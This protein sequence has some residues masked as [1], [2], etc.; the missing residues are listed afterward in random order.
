[1]SL[2]HPRLIVLTGLLASLG[3]SGARA[4]DETDEY[5]AIPWSQRGSVTQRVAYTDIRIVYSRPMA[6]GRTLFGGVVGWGGTWT[7][8][9]DSATT[10]SLSRAI[11]I[12]GHLLPAGRYSIW[13]VPRADS[14]WT[15]I[16]NARADVLH[17]P[18][19]GEQFD[20][21]RFEVEPSAGEYV[22]NLTFDMPTVARNS[23][24]LRFHWGTTVIALAIE[25][26]DEP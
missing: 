6:R 16:F 8:G 11:A 13:M 21:L 18:Y 19:P 4:Q 12:D 14:A 26:S 10:L 23:A 25:A 15:V 2:V 3:S 17:L 5:R 7:P 24:V 9:A 1:M 22:E 20:V